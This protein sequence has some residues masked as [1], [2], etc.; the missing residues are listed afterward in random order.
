M[1]HRGTFIASSRKEFGK[2]VPG[3]KHNMENYDYVL[4]DIIF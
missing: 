4:L 1:D 3:K 2:L